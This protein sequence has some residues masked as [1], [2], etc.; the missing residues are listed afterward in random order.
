MGA[1]KTGLEGFENTQGE[2]SN[3]ENTEEIGTGRFIDNTGEKI[4]SHELQVANE[5]AAQGKTVIRL[6]RE[7]KIEGVKTP[8]FKVDGVKT[9]IKHLENPNTT[10]GMGRVKDGFKQNA[11]KVIVDARGTGLTRQEAQIIIDRARGTFPNKT[12]PGVVE[13]WIDGE[14]ISYP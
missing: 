10:T 5:L 9:E 7:T 3:Q 1:G 13:V 2:R 4:S 8:D 14:I 6:P 12:L 11:E